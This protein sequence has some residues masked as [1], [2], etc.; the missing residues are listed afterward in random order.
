M[1]KDPQYSNA[2]GFY[3]IAK[4][5]YANKINNAAQTFIKNKHKQTIIEQNSEA[6]S[7]TNKNDTNINSSTDNT[8]DSETIK[9]V[10]N[11]SQNNTS[12]ESKILQTQQLVYNRQNNLNNNQN[13]LNNRNNRNM[14]GRRY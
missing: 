7:Y 2:D 3:N 10:N 8:N 14:F 13:Q 5:Y 12:K 6:V 1:L 11:D 4:Q 9:T